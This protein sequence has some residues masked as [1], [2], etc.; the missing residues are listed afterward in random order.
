MD[1]SITNKDVLAPRQGLSM[2]ML[3]RSY[4]L[5]MQ[6]IVEYN[7]ENP[8]LQGE[9]A[10]WCS[11]WNQGS[12]ETDESFWVDLSKEECWLHC[13]IDGSCY[14]AVYEIGDNGV[15][16][17]WTG[18]NKMTEVPEGWNRPEAT[19]TCFAKAVSVQPVT[20]REEKFISSNDVVTTTIVSDRPVTLQITGRSFFMDDKVISLNGSCSIDVASNSIQV[21]EGGR[22]MA[23]VAESPE[24][25]KEAMLMYEGMTGVLT[26]DHPLENVE[27][28]DISEGVCGYSFN[29]P[30]TEQGVS[31][32]WSMNDDKQV[33]LNAVQEVKIHLKRFQQEKT[34]LINDRLNNLIPYFRCSD[35]DV[36]K[37]YY[38]LWSIFLNYYKGPGKGMRSLPTTQSAVNNFLGLHRYDAVFQILVGSWTDPQYHD[39]YANGNVLTWA[40]TLPYRRDGDHLPDNFGVDWVSGVYGPETIAH[41][42]GL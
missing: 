26:S 24:V 6:M 40:N 3:E 9:Y 37:I 41:V 4:D 2:R 36:V 8:Y 22:V 13:E 28:H 12:T 5:L 27:L 42:Q 14:Q 18:T 32:L 34:D 38:Y 17:C 1:T 7:L 10:G 30:V 19:D 11:D 39:F 31:L 21:T 15:T 16:Q 35:N 29:L 20:V 33:A 25:W 23:K